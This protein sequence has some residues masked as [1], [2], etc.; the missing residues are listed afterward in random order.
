MK[1]R[2][3][4]IKHASIVLFIGLFFQGC[5]TKQ[6][7]FYWGEY[8]ELVHG[9]FKPEDGSDP[10]AQVQKLR[11]VIETAEQSGKKVAPGIHV[12]L[13]FMQHLTGDDIA[14]VRSLEKE[15]QLYPSSTKFV[16]RLIASLKGK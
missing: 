16:N 6:E 15:K 2:A 4:G 14:A 9:T 3:I 8:E 7:N 5:V 10:Q 12:H 1:I 13:G 11:E